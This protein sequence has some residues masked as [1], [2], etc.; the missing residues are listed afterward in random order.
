MIFD[1][2]PLPYKTSPLVDDDLD[3]E[4]VIRA[5]EKKNLENV[6][7]DETLEIDEI[8][9]IK[10]SKN[11][12][13]ENII[14]NLNQRILRSQLPNQSN[15]FCFILTIEP[16]SVN[17]ALTDKS[18]IVAMQEE[19]HQFI[20]NDVCEL[21]RL[22]AF[23]VKHEYKIGMVDNT[24]FTKKKSSN[25][26]IVQ[27]YIDDIIFGLTCQDMCDEF[28]KIMHDE[29]EMSMMGELNFFLGLQI[30]QME[31][32]IFFNQSKYIKEMLKKFGLENSKPM[33]TLMSSDT[34]LTKDEECKSVDSTKYRGMIGQVHR[35]RHEEEIDVHEYQ[36]LTREITPTMKPLD[37]I[38]NTPILT[39]ITAEAN[40]GSVDLQ[41]VECCG[42]FGY[43]VVTKGCLEALEL[44]GGDGGACKVLGWL[45]GDAREG[46]VSSI[47]T[48]LIW[49]DI[50][51]SD[52]L[53]SILLLV[54][55]IVMVIIVVVMV[56]LIVIVVAIV[57]VV[58]VVAI[59]GVVVVGGGVSSIIKLLFVIIGFLRRIML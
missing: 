50:I 5:T 13:L 23:P 18:W 15:F 21:D 38:C 42:G 57:V 33:K 6:V 29:F 47:P 3:K 43:K 32:G 4:E 24:L 27:I 59:I 16:K 34:K 7:E 40:L 52:G 44:K 46:K 2:T 53:P 31:D 11:H 10:E 9:H 25:L 26:I 39:N 12:T 17:E 8:A 36:I 35:I 22:K 54:V 49:V 30:K 37:E 58:F 51:S 55:I 19:L 20:A 14:G 45:L 1:E 56:I 48:V 41:G 28:A